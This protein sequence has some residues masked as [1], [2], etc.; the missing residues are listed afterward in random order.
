MQSALPQERTSTSM[1]A[2]I[3][4]SHL[5]WSTSNGQSVFFD[6]S[7]TFGPERVGIVGRNEVGK[8]T[9]LKL[10]SGV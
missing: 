4:V 5:A 8:T 7:L 10:L 6:L 2:L 1:S 3:T 9:L